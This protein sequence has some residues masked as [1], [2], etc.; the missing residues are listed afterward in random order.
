[1]SAD[2]RGV[3]AMLKA[4]T[5]QTPRRHLTYLENEEDSEGTESKSPNFEYQQQPFSKNLLYMIEIC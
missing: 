3:A 4:S 2:R 1:M 5:R